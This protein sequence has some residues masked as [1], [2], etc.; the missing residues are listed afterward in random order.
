MLREDIVGL[1]DELMSRDT[2]LTEAKALLQ[3]VRC[4]ICI[5]VHHIIPCTCTS[6]L[7]IYKT[8]GPYY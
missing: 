8:S 3:E 2:K 7:N 4:M 1:S 5:V 6:V